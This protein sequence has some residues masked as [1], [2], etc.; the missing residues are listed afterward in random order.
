MEKILNQL[1]LK[2]VYSHLNLNKLHEIVP[3]YVFLCFMSFI[4]FEAWC[5]SFEIFDISSFIFIITT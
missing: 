2:P 3:I 5:V 4:L 1:T